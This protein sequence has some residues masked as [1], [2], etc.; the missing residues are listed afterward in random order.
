[1]TGD[2]IREIRLSL[3]MSQVEFAAKLGISQ[4]AV[5]MY[6]QNRRNPSPRILTKIA[7]LAGMKA[8]DI[9]NN[10]LTGNS[11]SMSKREQNLLEAFKKLDEDDQDIIIGKVKEMIRENEKRS[12][13]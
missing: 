5:G 12:Q 13:S 8:G 9:L 11:S 4:S 10:D 3:G 1:M 6:E 2:V 7:E